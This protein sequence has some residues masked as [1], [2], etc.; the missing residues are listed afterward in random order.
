M[1]RAKGDNGG[2]INMPDNGGRLAMSGGAI[3]LNEASYLSNTGKGGN[4]GGVA[5][6]AQVPIDR[7]LPKFILEKG[8]ILSNTADING[9]GVYAGANTYFKMS[10]GTISSNSATWAEQN[11]DKNPGNGGGVYVDKSAL[12][13]ISGGSITQ[14]TA[15][16]SGGGVY[17]AGTME[18]S[19]KFTITDNSGGNVYLC[20]DKVMTVTGKLDPETR[21]GVTTE[22]KPTAENPV[23]LTKGLK[24]KGSVENFV[25]DDEKY[26]VLLND[27]GEAVLCL[28]VTITFEKGDEGASG[29]MPSVSVPS[30]VRYTLPENG[31]TA[32]AGNGFDGWAVAIGEMPAV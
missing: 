29:S 16:R 12:F 9:G 13:E 6:T 28:P 31:F 25:S 15:A 30:D 22:V 14:N 2:G 4:G 20:K 11:K 8:N 24:D 5:M 27:E 1:G 26:T 10:G 17:M 23:V 21:V 18:I 7:K 19:G 32:P 3:T